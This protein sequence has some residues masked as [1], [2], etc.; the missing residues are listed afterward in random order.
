MIPY[1]EVDQSWR[2]QAAC[3]GK[4]LR[5]FFHKNADA[6]ADYSYAKEICASCPV[7][8]QCL[9]EGLRLPMLNF[10]VWGGLTVNERR[11][12]RRNRRAA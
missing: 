4:P 8:R 6:G 1:P 5:L 7:R 9:E 2:D 10:G 3:I 12:L 11:N